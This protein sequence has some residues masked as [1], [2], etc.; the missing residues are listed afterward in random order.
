[1]PTNCQR[2]SSTGTGLLLRN[3]A[4]PLT[5]LN[6]ESTKKTTSKIPMHHSSQMFMATNYGTISVW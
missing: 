1:M 4:A 5:L 6:D 2:H 3:D